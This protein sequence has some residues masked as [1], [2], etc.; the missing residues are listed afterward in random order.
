MPGSGLRQRKRAYTRDTI[1]VAAWTVLQQSGVAGLTYR[2]VA[3]RAD[4]SDK[5]VAN[6]FP[7]KDE[8]VAACLDV[9]APS[10]DSWLDTST[11]PD[12]HPVTALRA[13][14]REAAQGITDAD[15]RGARKTMLAVAKDP[16]LRASYLRRLDAGVETLVAALAGRAAEH[17]LDEVGL[18]TAMA[19]CLA[20]VDAVGTSQPRSPRRDDWL[21]QLDEGLARVER[22]WVAA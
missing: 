14:L 4:V 11:W 1:V 20:V 6:Y 16:Q 18:R 13:A 9:S 7:T 12:G 5:T 17:G 10:P 22:G 8:L 15:V 21:R 3:E 19:A 2:D